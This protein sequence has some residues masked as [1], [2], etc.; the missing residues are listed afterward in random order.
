MKSLKIT[1]YLLA[2]FS[3]FLIANAVQASNATFTVAIWVK[4]TVSAASK[5]IAVKN[6]EIRIVT[7]A[8]GYLL[9]QFYNGSAWQTSVV[10]NEALYLNYWTHAACAYDGAD[11]KLYIDGILNNSAAETDNV[12]LTANPWILG[13]DVSTTYSDF[14]G[15]LDDAKLYYYV[16]TEDEI[17]QDYS[18]GAAAA[19][20]KKGASV[21]LGYKNEEWM[22]KGLVGYW[23]FDEYATTSG[24]LDSSRSGNDGEFMVSASTTSAKFGNG[25][26]FD[27]TISSSS[28]IVADNDNLD[29]MSELTLSAW[30][31]KNDANIQTAILGKNTCY[32]FRIDNEN[33]IQVGLAN[34]SGWQESIHGNGTIEIGQWVFVSVVYNGET[35]RFYI[36]GRLDKEVPY[37]I[38]AIWPNNPNSLRIGEVGWAQ[39]YWDGRIDEVRIYNRALS[40]DEIRKLSE[41]APGPVLRLKMDEK[42]G[43]TVYDTSGYGNE[44]GFYETGGPYWVSGKYGSAMRFNQEISDNGMK[45]LATSSIDIKDAMTIGFWMRKDPSII[46]NTYN[47]LTKAITYGYKIYTAGDGSPDIAIRLD[48]TAGTNQGGGTITDVI[49]NT[50]HHIAYVLDNGSRKAFKDGVLAASDTYNHGDG[51]SEPTRDLF[52]NALDT[53]IDMDDVRIYNYAR[54]QKQILEDMHADNPG[55]HPLASWNFDEGYGTTAYDASGNGKN[56]TLSSATRR[57]NEGRFDKAFSGTSNTRAYDDADDDNLDFA[58]NDDF[59]LSAWIK[60]GAD[61]PA[62]TEYI[63]HKQTGNEGYALYMDSSGRIGF[64]IGDTSSASFPEDA[65]LSIRD[66]ADNSWHQIVG[67][68]LSNQRIELFIDG[69]LIASD[70]ALAADGTLANSAV[71]YI[72]D[73]NATDD[74]DEFSG[75]IDEVKI[76][77]YALNEDEIKR[78]SNNGQSVLLGVRSTAS[79]GISQD[80][81]ADRSYCVPGDMVQCDPPVLHLKMDEKVSGN[82]K[83]LYDASGHGNDGT[84]VF[85]AN[86]SGMDCTQPGKFG[87][88]CKFDAKDDYVN[89]GNKEDLNITDELT[90]SAWVNLATTTGKYE[91][92]LSK[93]TNQVGGYSIRMGDDLYPNFQTSRDGVDDF[94]TWTS[95]LVPNQWTHIAVRYST[96]DN[97][98]TMYMDGHVSNVVSIIGAMATTSASFYLSKYGAAYYFPGRIDDV[99]VYDYARSAAQI[100][101]DYNRGKPVMEWRLDENT[102][103][104]IHDESGN[105]KHGVMTN[106]DAGT[107]W[108]AGRFNYALDFDGIN[109]HVLVGDTDFS[110]YYTGMYVYAL[111]FWAN[112]SSSTCGIIDLDGGTHTIALSNGQITANGFSEP[113][114]YIDGVAGAAFSN[115]GWHHIFVQGTT[116]IDVSNL[117]FGRAGNDYFIGKLDEIRI[118]NYYLTSEQIKQSVNQKALRFGE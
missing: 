46:Q 13:H 31:Y 45:C 80:F 22:S 55:S 2:V 86:A 84:T 30:V 113:A 73:A 8:S 92:V 14:Q 24:A 36:D 50:W 103:T 52:F 87:T 62:D 10:A 18:A 4:P 48:T 38:G 81:S 20:V 17:H 15:Y 90:I 104:D 11:M 93:R 28:V 66:Y 26:V 68:K 110:I 63:I 91:A 61:N 51:F 32:S 115:S 57:I 99:R 117:S 111:A 56:L 33:S 34:S 43:D 5:A 101:W 35:L 114:I 85:G 23:K 118:Y 19:G 60:Y 21:A 88:A 78:E 40:A 64:G 108:T 107:D 96:A 109:D 54:T 3:I 9:C 100:Y 98:V 67:R 71:L 1:I 25:A 49:D 74:A 47:I 116:S 72:G 70:I 42:S 16:R 83:T 75:M 106:M 65:A 7:D 27:G 69:E 39:N 37:S 12:N 76:F 97:K 89:V 95:P 41:W 112:T 82:G 79:D 102:G 6:Q 59:S 53:K 29:G 44:C 77:A 94:Y 105:G 58:A